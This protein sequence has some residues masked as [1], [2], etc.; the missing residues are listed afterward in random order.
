M[1]SHVM[2]NALFPV[3]VRACLT[4]PHGGEYILETLSRY[5]R[6][7][8]RMYVRAVLRALQDRDPGVGYRQDD[9]H[10]DP[11]IYKP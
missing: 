8:R 1:D 3:H 6:I 4:L 11:C 5:P 9:A 2:L 7:T 10:G